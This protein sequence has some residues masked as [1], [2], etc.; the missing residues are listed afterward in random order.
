MGAS[1]GLLAANVLYLLLGAGLVT[2]FGGA[3]STRELVRRLGLAYMAGVAVAGMLAAQLALAGLALGLLPLAA[4]A[5]VSLAVGLHRFRR[6]RRP[7]PAPVASFW[8]ARLVAGAALAQVGLLIGVATTAFLVRPII[9]WDAWAIWGL[10]A[11]ALFWL[12]GVS[13]PV[14]ESPVYASHMLDYPL[15]LPA[16]E[17]TG[18]HAMGRVDQS[19]IQLQL[20]ALA[21]GF[22]WALWGILRP[23]VPVEIAALALLALIAAPNVL[24]RL[25]S[26]YADIPLAFFVALGL[27]ALG[28]WLLEPDSR[29]LP[30]VALFLGA[31]GLTKNE[32]AMFAATALLSALAVVFVTD[33]ARVRRL[34]LA[35][36][37]VFAPL[38]PWRVFVATHDLHDVAF[39]PGDTARPGYLVHHADRLWPAA[40]ALIEQLTGGGYGLLLPALALAIAAAIVARRAA[41]AVFVAGWLTLSFAGLLFVYWVSPL[42]LDWYLANSADRV[43]LTLV[44]GGAAIA[45]LLA[46]D[47]WRLVL[48]DWRAARAAPDPPPLAVDSRASA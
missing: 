32:G 1:G 21:V 34:L 27:A 46:G 37:C 31:A 43:V 45:P 16:L 19:L 22:A 28:R 13:N 17:S 8:G 35:S 11:R 38:V 5:C 41:L 25:S 42:S 10:R 7:E 23:R 48:A 30:W 44:I 33:R 3:R 18:F 39:A 47:A 26:G 4:L 24:T 40:R 2:A 29:L 36:L 20:L 14:F 12:G 9:D 15:F 6:E